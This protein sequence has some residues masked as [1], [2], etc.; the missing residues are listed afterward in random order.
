NALIYYNLGLKG[1]YPSPDDYLSKPAH[2]AFDAHLFQDFKIR[3]AD[4]VRYSY[5]FIDLNL[6]GT[7]KDVNK[8]L[9]NGITVTFYKRTLEKH[10]EKFNKI[11]RESYPKSTPALVLPS[12]R[13]N[14]AEPSIYANEHWDIFGNPIASKDQYQAYRR[15]ALPTDEDRKLVDHVLQ[16]GGIGAP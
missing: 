16:N 15:A 9:L 14:R 3:E 4:P 11:I 10:F 8:E 12:L 2:V 13:W 6:G 5:K 1:F 7:T